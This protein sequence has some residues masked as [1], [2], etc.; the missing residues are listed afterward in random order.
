[1]NRAYIDRNTTAAVKGIALLI[2]FLHHFFLFPEWNITDI[3]YPG[4]LPF[5][6]FLQNPTKICVVVFAFITG[7]F[8]H[9]AR[10]KTVRYSLGKIRGFL[11]SYWVVLAILMI[12]AVALGYCRLTPALFIKELFGMDKQIMIFCWYVS[13]YILTMLALPLLTSL[14]PNRPGADILIMLILPVVAAVS[15]RGVLESEFG[16]EYGMVYVSAINFGDWFPCVGAGYLCAKYGIF[17]TYLDGLFSRIRSSWGKGIL[18]VLMCLVAFFGRVLLCRFQLGSIQICGEWKELWFSMDIIYGPMFLYGIVN[19]LKTIKTDWI[20]KP[21][22]AIG[23]QSMYM[24]FFHC[25]FFNS[26][27]ELTQPVLYAL[28]NPLLVFLTGLG[29]CYLAA[30]LVD[31][32]L[33][34]LQKR[35]KIL[36]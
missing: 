7:Y 8:Y 34:K 33:K 3:S 17:E 12:P 26:C 29:I 14:S 16:I 23:K 15:I 35:K 18:W 5:I 20:Q 24:W 1:M 9:F 28:R 22:T 25:A 2:M 6:R 21:L 32:P 27:S 11:I 36:E 31:I 10:E 30:V 19:L 4:I 13:F